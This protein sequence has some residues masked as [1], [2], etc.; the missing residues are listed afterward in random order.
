M[1]PFGAVTGSLPDVNIDEPAVEYL[2]RTVFPTLLTGIEVLLGKKREAGMDGGDKEGIAWLAN[3][4]VEH[5]PMREESDGSG[6][7]SVDQE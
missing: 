4:L 5:N 1:T 2:Y 3:Y 6:E 7:E